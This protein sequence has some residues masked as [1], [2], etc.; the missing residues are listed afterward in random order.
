MQAMLGKLSESRPKIDL[1]LFLQLFASCFCCFNSPDS[2]VFHTD[3]TP[4][5]SNI[6]L[7][8]FYFHFSALSDAGL[9]QCVCE[10]SSREDGA[11]RG[12]AAGGRGDRDVWLQLQ[13]VGPPP[14]AL[15]TRAAV[16]WH[17]HWCQPG[18]HSSSREPLPG[19]CP[20]GRCRPGD[21]TSLL[22][23]PEN[24]IEIVCDVRV[25]IDP[26]SQVEFQ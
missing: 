16:G 26:T 14:P 10:A 19:C 3:S 8:R 7:I 9:P 25:E 5:R 23:G 17:A 21:P 6:A 15:C 2:S 18:G 24:S 11:R 1:H 12:N 20:L 13:A 4:S 22:C